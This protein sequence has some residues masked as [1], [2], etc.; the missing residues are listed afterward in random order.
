MLTSAKVETC[1]T[2]MDRPLI[3]SFM[4][5]LWL[6]DAVLPL[7]LLEEEIRLTLELF[8]VY[9]LKFLFEDFE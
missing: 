4:F 3:K 2:L 1:S 5:L 6:S 9:G 7:E 8:I